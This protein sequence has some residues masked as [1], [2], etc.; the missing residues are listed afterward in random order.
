MTTA[1]LHFDGSPLGDYDPAYGKMLAVL[2]AYGIPYERLGISGHAE[3]YYLRYMIDTIAPRIL[4]PLHSFRPEQVCSERA[5]RR[6][7]PE[8]G[9]TITL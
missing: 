1:F 8:P 9:E 7:L 2:E 5:G 4:V 6:L 3:P